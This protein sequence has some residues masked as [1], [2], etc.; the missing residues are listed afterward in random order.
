MIHRCFLILLLA[1]LLAIAVVCPT[2][3]ASA[4]TFLPDDLFGVDE[5]IA[6][7]APDPIHIRD[8]SMP[9]AQMDFQASGKTAEGNGALPDW[10]L[11]R[12]R[13]F[14]SRSDTTISSIRDP[15]QVADRDGIFLRL[16][17]LPDDLLH[18]P[19][20][21][22]ETVGRIFEPQLNLGLEF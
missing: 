3:E 15:G 13:L 8:I 4:G 14:W 5:D 22:A 21:A 6:P 20:R 17:V 10:R 2:G 1:G 11:G 7:S 18:N 16:K 12:F 19:S 9:G